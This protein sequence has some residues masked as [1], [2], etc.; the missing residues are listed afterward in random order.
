MYIDT[1]LPLYRNRWWHLPPVMGKMSR[2]A[3]TSLLRSTTKL[4][5]LVLSGLLSSSF[6][7]LFNNCSC[8]LA[9]LLVHSDGGGAVVDLFAEEEDE[10]G[11]GNTAAMVQKGQVWG[12]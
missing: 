3:T 7:I 1:T 10:E 4:L 2:K 8:S 11:K 12:G 9:L 5:G 6:G